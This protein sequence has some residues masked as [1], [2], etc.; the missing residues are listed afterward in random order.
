[1]V[2]PAMIALCVILLS[3]GLVAIFVR[4]VEYYTQPNELD[5]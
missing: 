1:M 5:Q 3:I 4:F 2:D